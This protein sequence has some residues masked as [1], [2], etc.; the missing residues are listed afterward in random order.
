MPTEQYLTTNQVAKLLNL[1]PRTLEHMRC[2]GTGPAFCKFGRKCLY[3]QTDIDK[4]VEANLCISTSEV[5]IR[6]QPNE[7]PTKSKLEEKR[8]RRQ[9]RRKLKVASNDSG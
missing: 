7:T 8:E 9:K 6:N 2:K 4:W 5:A 3:R 1:S